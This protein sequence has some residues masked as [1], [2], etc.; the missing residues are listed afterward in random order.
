MLVSQNLFAADSIVGSW[1]SPEKGSEWIFSDNGQFTHKPKS[2]T[3]FT[4]A[5]KQEGNKVTV[6]AKSVDGGKATLVRSFEIKRMSSTEVDILMEGARPYTW[7]KL[8]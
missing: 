4:G 6:D 3:A 8:K 5:W 1:I 7:K 2:G